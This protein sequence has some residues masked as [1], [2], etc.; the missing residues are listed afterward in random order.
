MDI[1][2][3][4]F[5]VVDV[6]DS[7]AAGG[8]FEVILSAPTKDRDGEVID[9]KA[10]E[11]LPDHITF[12]TDHSMTCDSVVGSGT[13]YYA[14]DGTLRVSGTYASDER[15][16]VIRQKV[17]DGHIRTTS[18]TFM[19]AERVEKDGVQHVVSAELLNGTFTPVPSNREAVVLTAKSIV[20]AAV[21]AKA[22][23][24]N[25]KS[26]AE[27]I[28][29]MHDGALALGASCES[30][31]AHGASGK[32]ADADENDDD[33]VTD[34]DGVTDDNPDQDAAGDQDENTDSDTDTSADE[35][36][37]DAAAAASSTDETTDDSEGS[38]R[39]KRW[40]Q[41]QKSAAA[42]FADDE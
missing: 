35:S 12:D 6:K 4:D 17:A 24:R 20:Q 15:S 41:A 42:V 1:V 38:E 22:G 19:A 9:A 34:D 31:S 37:D 36:A 13:P 8:A 25:N 7:D 28:Q 27:T 3:K 40:L 23:A 32:N 39:A 29:A 10:F 33:T 30:K 16:Q 18:V 21:A 5:P 14:D 11:P 26:D 2:T